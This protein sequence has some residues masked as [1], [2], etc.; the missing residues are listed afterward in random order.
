MLG[1]RR[2]FVN[3]DPSLDWV[4]DDGRRRG[5]GAPVLVAHSTPSFAAEHL[6]TRPPPGRRSPALQADLEAASRSAH[7]HRWTF[8]RPPGD[9]PSPSRYRDR[10]GLCGDAWSE[11]PRVEGAYLSGRA[12][13]EARSPGHTAG[14]L[15]HVGAGPRA[16]PDARCVGPS[17]RITGW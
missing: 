14:P 15:T 10:L 4:A 13:A 3:D 1:L 7:V 9:A 17:Q 12:L 5:D 16:D 11:K 6:W 8:A 2:A